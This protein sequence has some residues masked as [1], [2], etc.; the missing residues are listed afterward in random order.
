MIKTVSWMLTSARAVISAASDLGLPSDEA[1]CTGICPSL[2]QQHSGKRM[3]NCFQGQWLRKITMLDD[4]QVIQPFKKLDT[5][6]CSMQVNTFI[7]PN[8][9][10]KHDNCC[11]IETITC[12]N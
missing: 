6:I 1:K 11:G 10:A 5:R 3:L 9:H 7:N 2:N 8:I 4:S 12:F